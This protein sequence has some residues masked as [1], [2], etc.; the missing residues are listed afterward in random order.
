VVDAV[1]SGAP[2][3][4]IHRLDA[5]SKEIPRQFFHYS[6]HALGVTEAVQLARALNQLPPRLI[7][8]GIEGKNFGAGVGLSTEVEQASIAVAARVLDEVRTLNEGEQSCTNSHS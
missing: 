1:Y 2:P 3:G 4:T 8:Y 5:S 7:V 6:T